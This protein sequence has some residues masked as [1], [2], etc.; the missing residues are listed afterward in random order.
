MSIAEKRRRRGEEEEEEGGREGRSV[1]V[2]VSEE[3]SV[4]AS[5]RVCESMSEVE[6]SRRREVSFFKFSSLFSSLFSLVSA[7]SD[8]LTITMYAFRCSVCYV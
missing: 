2:R 3:T 7:P 4:C 8:H 5:G 6:S 1:C